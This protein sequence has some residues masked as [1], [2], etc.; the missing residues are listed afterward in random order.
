MNTIKNNIISYRESIFQSMENALKNHSR[1]LIYGLGVTDHIG[2][3][4]T[5]K[6]LEKKYGK[7]RVLET[8]IAEESMTGFA[9]GLS[10][11]KLYPIH[12]HIRVDFMMLAMN[13]LVNHIAKY[14]YMYGGL[15]QVPM[16]I[17]AVIGR[18]WGQG[19][20]H[21]QSLQSLFAHIPGLTVIMPASAKSIMTS[22]Q[23][24]IENYPNPVI[25]L[26]H[27]L[28]YEYQFDLDTDKVES[29]HPFSSRLIKEGKDITVIATSITVQDALRAARYIAESQKIDIEIIDLHCI[30]HPNE[31]MI[32]DSV[33]KTGKCLVVDTSWESYGVCAEVARI[34]S[35]HSSM[36]LKQPIET[37]SMSPAPCPT[38][39]PL[40]NIFYPSPRDIIGKIYS[41][42][43][44]EKK[45]KYPLPSLKDINKEIQ[46][47]K[48]PF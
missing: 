38:T 46:E 26:E 45:I 13:Q 22:Y 16:L 3:F 17:R 41:M 2:I 25:S 5:V 18:S 10:L 33:K 23:H 35:T 48:G 7:N 19:S 20:Q 24:A 14:R 11:A 30:S 36:P 29:E 44:S 28:L 15:F 8:P 4:G 31:K 39:K 42:C 21:S 37:L 1:T 12:I 27:R 6:G 43:L 9:L 40:E 34:L 32:V 47:F